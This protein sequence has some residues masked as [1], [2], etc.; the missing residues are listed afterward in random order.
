MENLPIYWA[1]L[2]LHVLLYWLYDIVLEEKQ[3]TSL[4]FFSSP[5]VYKY[6]NAQGSLWL[7]SSLT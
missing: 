3:E 1:Y 2:Q 6:C 7:V 4:L 5:W